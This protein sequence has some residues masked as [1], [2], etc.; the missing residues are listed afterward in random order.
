MDAPTEWTYGGKLDWSSADSLRLAPLGMVL[1]TINAAINERKLTS[2]NAIQPLWF[3]DYYTIYTYCN[4]LHP[5][6]LSSYINHTTLPTDSEIIP[7]WTE[8]ALEEVLGEEL[9]N[10]NRLMTFSAEWAYQQYRIINLLKWKKADAQIYGI[11]GAYLSNSG[12]NSLV[13]V[14]DAVNEAISDFPYD[15]GG[16]TSIGSSSVI[17]ANRRTSDE[18]RAARIWKSRIARND[19]HKTIYVY[20]SLDYDLEADI[21]IVV[22]P[23]RTTSVFLQDNETHVTTINDFWDGGI[24]LIENRYNV[25]KTSSLKIISP[26]E[27]NIEIEPLDDWDFPPAPDEPSV[28]GP[29]PNYIQTARGFVLTTTDSGWKMPYSAVKFDGANG[30]KFRDW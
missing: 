12:G 11:D 10:L 20:S 7:V 28:Y 22:F 14:S 24:G 25:I 4:A 16:G 13:S 3:L 30:F 5:S 6:L 17:V 9:I 8:N 23:V 19:G 27:S 15:E 21:D 1:R 18:L 2:F 29:P 26:G